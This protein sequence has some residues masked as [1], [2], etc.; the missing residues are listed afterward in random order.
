MREAANKWG[1]QTTGLSISFTSDD[2]HPCAGYLSAIPE[3]GAKNAS[4][5]YNDVCGDPF[6]TDVIAVTL[7]Q[8]FGSRYTESDIVF[9]I[10]ESWRVYDGTPIS[11]LDFR[12]VA[13]HEFGHLIGLDHE[14]SNSAIMA[15]FIGGIF[16]PTADDLNGSRDIYSPATGGGDN[17]GN[18]GGGSAPAIRAALEEPSAGQ[19]ASGVTNIR[20]WAVGTAGIKSISL[21][22]DGS[23][24]T[25]IPYGGERADVEQQF[26]NYLNPKESGYSMSFY[27]GNLTP[28]LH[29]IEIRALD[30]AGR[31][32]SV[33]S[34]FTVRSFG[35]AFISDPNSVQILSGATVTDPQTVTLNTVRV[36][37]QNHKVV[38]KWNTASQKWDI[39]EID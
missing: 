23:Y 37:G 20:G 35:N 22:I 21:Y 3:D 11:S 18:N 24:A 36:N 10:G 30:N 16:N 26:P 25:D 34:D 1:D 38:L 31:T 39:D 33:K 5:F 8:S 2:R 32:E 6:G 13:V 27:W 17:G 7:S 29:N 15:P 19:P 12:R 28:G 4:G 14:E 9:N